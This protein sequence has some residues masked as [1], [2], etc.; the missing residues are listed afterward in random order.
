MH[1]LLWIWIPGVAA[2]VSIVVVVGV[3]HILLSLL[4]VPIVDKQTKSPIIA[5]RGDGL[6]RRRWRGRVAATVVV[7]TGGC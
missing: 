2:A 1:K 6:C 7:Q 5:I 4:V 3:M